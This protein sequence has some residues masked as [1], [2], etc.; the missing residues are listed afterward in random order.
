MN[1]YLSAIEKLNISNGAKSVLKR[2]NKVTSSDNVTMKKSV[3]NLFIV[4]PHGAG[5]SEYARLYERIIISNG[6]YPIRGKGTY[7]ELA[8]PRM[9]SEKDYAAFFNSPRLVAATQNDFTGVFLISFEQWNSYNDILKDKAFDELLAFIDQNKGNISFVFHVLKDFYDSDKLARALNSHVNLEKLQLTKPML[10]EAI[11]YVT[12]EMMKTNIILTDGAKSNL[13]A[14]IRN[15][16]NT[17]SQAY[18]G[19]ETL[20]RL[21]DD[22]IYEVACFCN[23]DSNG[24]RYVNS[25]MLISISKSINFTLD[26]IEAKLKVGF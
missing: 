11:D 18:L 15:R 6:V 21:A 17:E 1:G 3:K 5:L 4:C 26:D 8:F 9:G 16:V 23:A 19:F 14:L 13:E 12:K 2:V 10:S 20:K 24:D 7:L 25:E 22:I